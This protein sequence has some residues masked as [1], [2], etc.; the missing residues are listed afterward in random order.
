MTRYYAMSV[1]FG[2]FIG[3]YIGNGARFELVGAIAALYVRMAI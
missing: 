3:A 1:V 2:G